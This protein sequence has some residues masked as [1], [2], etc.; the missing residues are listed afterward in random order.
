MTV[1]VRHRLNPA[2]VELTCPVHGEWNFPPSAEVSIEAF[3]Q[4]HADCWD[5]ACPT[6]A[7]L[8]QPRRAVPPKSRR[9]PLQLVQLTPGPK[10]NE[11]DGHA[12]PGHLGATLGFAPAARRDWRSPGAVRL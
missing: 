5:P 7:E 3:E 8:E 12:A 9:T 2:R 6:A 1:A 11:P 10:S 4:D